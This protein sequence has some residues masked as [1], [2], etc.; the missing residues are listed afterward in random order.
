RAAAKSPAPEPELPSPP[1][2]SVA[3]DAP[4][5]SEF[6]DP[7]GLPSFLSSYRHPAPVARSRHAAWSLREPRRFDF[8]Q[9]VHAVLLTLPEIRHA[10][11]H[12]PIVFMSTPPHAPLALLG[13]QP[14]ENFFVDAAGQW[15]PEAYIPAYFRRYPF[16]LESHVVSGESRLCLDEASE[17]LS[18]GPEHAPLFL[19]NGDPAPT[20]QAA[21]EFCRGFHAMHLNTLEMTRALLANGVLTGCAIELKCHQGI[22][23]LSDF[24]IVNEQALEGLSPLLLDHW[25]RMGWLAALYWHILSLNLWKRLVTLKNRA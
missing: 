21:L 16:M 18:Q 22:F 19:D 25:R 17:D 20:V 12:Y 9:T 5:S 13:I 1:P 4:P 8:A 24:L 2:P 3:A 7:L 15:D 10:A 14:G 6:V 23:R 11:S